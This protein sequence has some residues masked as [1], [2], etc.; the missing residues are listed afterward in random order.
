MEIKIKLIK[1]KQMTHEN[2]YHDDI[3]D[4]N[5]KKICKL[6]HFNEPVSITVP[7]SCLTF[8]LTRLVLSWVDKEN[9]FFF[10]L[11]HDITE[12]LLKV[13][14]STKLFFFFGERAQI[15]KFCISG[16][17][18]QFLFFIQSLMHIF[19]LNMTT[20]LGSIPQFFL[21]QLCYSS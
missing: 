15:W 19:P 4:K 1:R 17:Y 10:I 18:T 2:T 8:T 6:I 3:F 13:A 20:S 5:E 14:L 11:C 9:T 7:Q 12:I 16:R 21:S